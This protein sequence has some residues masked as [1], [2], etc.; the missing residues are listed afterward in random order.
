MAWL[1]YDETWQATRQTDTTTMH[2]VSV[3]V[4][5]LFDMEVFLRGVT[6]FSVPDFAS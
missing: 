3:S 2:F 6:T 1:E 5:E 4:N